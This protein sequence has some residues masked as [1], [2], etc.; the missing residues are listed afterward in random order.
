MVNRKTRR[1][2]RKVSRITRKVRRS[3]KVSRRTRKVRRSRKQRGGNLNLDILLP[4][5]VAAAAITV[6][7]NAVL[8][9]ESYTDFKARKVL[10][11]Y[12]HNPANMRSATL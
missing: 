4:S 1:L 10:K 12:K 7:A 3:R 9:S 6:V 11:T 2:N 8:N 5:A